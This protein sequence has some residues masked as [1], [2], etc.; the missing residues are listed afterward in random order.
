MT[1]VLHTT[2]ISNVESFM[3]GMFELGEEI[4]KDVRGLDKSQYEQVSILIT[5]RVVHFD[6]DISSI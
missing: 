6:G 5:L 2:R 4:V 3:M 1:R